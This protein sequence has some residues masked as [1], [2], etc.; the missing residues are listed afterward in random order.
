MVRGAAGV[1]R[2][3][4]YRTSRA[5]RCWITAGARSRRSSHGYIGGVAPHT[6]VHGGSA[7]RVALDRD[8]G[9]GAPMAIQP[10][11][12]AGRPVGEHGG[13][14]RGAHLRRH[15]HDGARSRPAGEGP[16]AARRPV[17]RRGPDDHGFRG[18]IAASQPGGRPGPAPID[19]RRS[20]GAAAPRSAPH[21][22]DASGRRTPIAGQAASR[23]D[24]ASSA[25][26]RRRL[27]NYRS[28]RCRSCVVRASTSCGRPRAGSRSAR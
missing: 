9:G 20:R 25:Y 26:G 5:G 4:R 24:E 3:W 14:T 2:R 16:R 17:G 18:A 23:S 19:P 28:S 15:H 27:T 22:A 10:F 21:P 12:G 6:S 13:F 11:V 8:P 7:A 1:G